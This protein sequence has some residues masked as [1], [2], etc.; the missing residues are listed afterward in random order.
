MQESGGREFDSNGELVTSTPGAMGLMQLMPP[1]YDDMRAQYNLGD[2]PY[3]PHDNIFAGT[4]YIR[5]MY[6]IYGSPGFL[7]AYNDG[8]GNLDAYL[9][10]GHALP[11]ETRRYVASVGT[12][13]AGIWPQNRSQA[14]ILV[15]QHDP[16][17]P[18]PV[19]VARNTAEAQSVK[20]AWSARMGG[21]AP[22]PRHVTHHHAAPIAEPQPIQ[23]AEAE[24]PATPAPAPA[25]TR[26]WDSVADNRTMARPIPRSDKIAAQPV[27]DHPKRHTLSF[28]LIPSAM[29][30]PLPT[31]HHAPAATHGSSGGDWA[32]QVGAYS[33]A[34]QAHTAVGRAHSGDS[35]LAH[36]ATLVAPVSSGHAHLYRARLTGLSHSDAVAACKHLSGHNKPCVVVSPGGF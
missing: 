19:M 21:S 11:R 24:E 14:D 26:H 3:D 7:A 10:R 28:H 36:A 8:P 35:H 25:Y 17:V 13:I 2:D 15:A 1:T 23:V 6:D 34:A 31:I 22:A 16:N 32:I 30:E 33:S 5:Q 4:A 20:D 9:R 29:A 18:S 27:V 12:K